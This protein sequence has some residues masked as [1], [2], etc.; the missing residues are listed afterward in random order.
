MRKWIIRGVILLL[1]LLLIIVLFRAIKSGDSWSSWA[2]PLSGKVIVLD[3]GHGGPDGG[4][5][6]KGNVLEKEIALAISLQLRDYL[7]QAG[8]LVIMTRETD[9]DLAGRDVQGLSRR[10]TDD[11][12]KRLSIINESNGDLFLSVHL[13]VI[14]SPRWRGAQTFYNPTNE[15]S[16]A[17]SLFI[18]DELRRNLENTD[19][20]AKHLSN[21]F[22]LKEA[23]IPGA[24]VE[25]GFLSN[26]S[27]NELLQQTPYQNKIAASIYQGILRYY[28]EE[29][30][31][32]E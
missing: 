1:L 8:A 23:D 2:L 25:V 27:E 16:E 6:G 4:A 21:I 12:Y 19:R 30:L 9:Q 26:P 11:L 13:N 5:V 7:Q 17:V 32:K 20:K 3:P 28:A 14:P 18:Q 10:K 24:I 31:P 15:E 22:I 29:E